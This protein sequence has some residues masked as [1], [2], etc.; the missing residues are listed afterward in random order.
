MRVD[1][2]SLTCSIVGMVLQ[3][4][5]S[6]LEVRD[7]IIYIYKNVYMEVLLQRWRTSDGE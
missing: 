1:H 7:I 3:Q 5:R 4:N 6:L 2:H